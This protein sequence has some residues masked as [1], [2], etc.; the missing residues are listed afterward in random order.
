M[1]DYSRLKEHC[2]QT[3]KLP[4]SPKTA[5]EHLTVLELIQYYEENEKMKR[6]RGRVMEQKLDNKLILQDGATP[7][8]VADAVIRECGDKEWLEDIIFFLRAYIDRTYEGEK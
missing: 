3:L 8:T 7:F 6:K 5:A 1:N 4:T 2:Y